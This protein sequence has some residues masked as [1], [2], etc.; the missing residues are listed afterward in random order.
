MKI[1]SANGKAYGCHGYEAGIHERKWEIDSLC[2]PIRLSHG[3]CRKRGISPPSTHPGSGPCKKI[4]KTFREQQQRKDGDG[5]YT[6]QRK[7]SW[8][9]MA[10]PWEAM[11]TPP[12]GWA[13][14]FDVPAQRRCHDLSLPHPSNLF[15]LNSLSNLRGLCARFVL[16]GRGAIRLSGSW[17]TNVCDWSMN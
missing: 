3:Y 5:P 1:R 9:T 12:E 15:A 2:Y 10:C 14:P 13:D 17:V 6:F 11:V 4:V 16:K 8:A 7:T